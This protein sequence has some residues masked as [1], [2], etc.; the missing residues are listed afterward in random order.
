[1]KLATA[2]AV[3]VPVFAFSTVALYKGMISQVFNSEDRVAEPSFTTSIVMCT[4][5]EEGFIEKALKSLEE[6]NVVKAYPEKFDYILIDSN[7]TDGTV[8]IAKE[9]GWK[10][11]E[12]PLGKLNARHVGMEKAKGKVIVS[13]DAD[14]FYPPNYL[15]LL[16]KWFRHPDVVAVVAPR[17]ANPEESMFFS[18][19]SVW[20]ALVETG[21]LLIGGMRAPGQSM[22]LYRQAYFD[23]GG[24]DLNINQQ[25]VHEMSREEE[26]RFAMKLRRLGRVPVEWRAPCFTSLRRVKFIKKGEAYERWQNERL[27]GLRF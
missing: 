8:E 24:F 2:L 11:Y 27:L 12:A 5:N 9:H 15:N 16:L 3:G 14:C 26:I 19:V 25:N 21:P 7:S 6:Q 1:L 22:A 20:M 23:V 4:L 13:V 10:V 18:Y 17:L